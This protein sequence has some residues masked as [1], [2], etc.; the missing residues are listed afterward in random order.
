MK[1][2]PGL[3]YGAVPL[4]SPRGRASLVASL[5]LFAGACAASGCSGSSAEQGG[6]TGDASSDASTEAQAE[7][8][9]DSAGPAP[10]AGTDS[11][12]SRDGATPDAGV[13][14]HAPDGATEAATDSGAGGDSADE[15]GGDSGSTGDAARDGGS[16]DSGTGGGDSA[17]PTDSGAADSPADVRPDGPCTVGSCPTGLACDVATGACT[18]ACSVTQ[19]CTG[20]CCIGGTCAVG[21]GSAPDAC[22]PVGGAC[23]DCT[24]SGGNPAGNACLPTRVCGCTMNSNCSCGSA[25]CGCNLATN[26]CET[27]AIT[28]F[29]ATPSTV[30]VTTSST[31]AWTTTG[32]TSCSIDHGVGVVSCNG[33][34]PVTP[35]SDTTYTLTASG[36]GGTTTAK[37]SVSLTRGAGCGALSPASAPIVAQL[38]STSPLPPFDGGFL[39]DGTYVLTS[40]VIYGQPDNLPTG[41]TNQI[42]IVLS[43]SASGTASMTFDQLRP[44]GE[45]GASG[46]ITPVPATTTASLAITCPGSMSG[47]LG[48]TVSGSNPVVFALQ[49]DVTGTGAREVWTFQKQ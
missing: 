9:S 4:L 42:V 18:P 26:A 37:A 34:K 23:L 31:L 16:T 25:T 10:E 38:D 14:S 46:T 11:G 32:A 28:S 7:A 20:T 41:N 36:G 2:L 3:P 19:P 35:S 27:T 1:K 49:A 22:G 30:D 8:G 15:G 45:V 44:S 33:S 24:A 6:A 17:T 12:A 43:N 29:T 48:Y 40:D 47:V 21:G 5:L 13:D 39:L